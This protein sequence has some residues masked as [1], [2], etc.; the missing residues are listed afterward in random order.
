MQKGSRHQH[1]FYVLVILCL[2][3]IVS[4]CSAAGSQGRSSAQATA[5]KHVT[6]TSIP[7]TPKNAPSCGGTSCTVTGN[8]S[9]GRPFINTKNN[10]HLFLSFD[11]HISDPSAI[12][13]YY[14]FV[15]GASAN[16]VAAYRAANPNILLSYYISFFRDSGVFGDTSAHQSLAY[17]QSVHPDW[18]L[19]RCDRQTP[20]FEDNQ[21][22][23]I[24]FDFTNPAVVQWQVQTYALPASQQG[25][26]AIA[27]DNVNLQN[28]TG[29]C[30]FYHNGQWVQRY[31][32]DVD[33]AQWRADV[34][35][36]LTRTQQAL[37]ALAHPMALI[38]NLGIGASLNDPILQQII[39]HVDAV[40][41]ESGF[42]HYG[43]N[44]L[45]D[46]NWLQYVHFVES[47][48]QQ[49]KAYYIVNEFPDAPLTQADIE[50]ALSSYLM[51]NQGLAAVFFS[52]MQGYG[53]DIYVPFL[54]T[55]I[56]SP[57]DTLY[58][59]Q[60]I[61]WR[62][63]THALSVVNPSSTTTYTV[64]LPGHYTDLNGNALG[65]TITLPPH[66]G[67]VLLY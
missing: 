67:Q 16:K 6:P 25:Y 20:A 64:N 40:V 31:T 28:L 46:A 50:W 65:A 27:A 9:Q 53:R 14:D 42:T 32:G 66:T 3:S 61:Y 10:I 35:T 34:L 47:V 4:S 26:D 13:Q 60:H 55:Q 44:D 23:I 43:Q 52:S 38:P 49:H 11:Y 19:Y 54:S 2:V 8:V 12:A 5:G 59:G 30:G 63:F 18:I 1:L 36:W 17:W 24:P 33:D 22:N 45:T 58:Q 15:W 37:H 56:G 21:N 51:A 29:A 57:R 39:A 48:Q 41:D 7:T 62:D